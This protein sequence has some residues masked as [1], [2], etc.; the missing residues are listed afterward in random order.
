[1]I[2]AEDLT[3]RYGSKSAVRGLSLQVKPGKVY[4]LL[5]PNGAGKTT[6]LRMLSTLVRPTAGR[7]EV[8]GFDVRK[9]PLEVRRRLG[10]VNGGMR[11]YDRL[12]GQEVLAFFASF[13]GL[14]GRAFGEALDW[15]VA[16]LEMEDTL[17]KKVL[18]MSTGMRQKVVIA[19]AI[20][21]RPPVLLLDEA[22]AGLDVFARRALLD[23]VKAYRDL[24]NTVLYSTHVMS[25]A[26]EVADRVGFLHQGRL[27]YEG[28]MEE[29]LAMGEGSLE[30][31]FIR[32]VKEAA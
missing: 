2:Q 3:K 4:A 11:V 27:V 10:L 28:S 26:E 22:T 12:T 7:A 15:V 18:E 1:M 13:Y 5:G 19:R 32:K 23:F 14:E 16:L 21:H 30:K 17:E 9:K 25:E 31:A 8:A 20:L 6:T 29:A 24:G